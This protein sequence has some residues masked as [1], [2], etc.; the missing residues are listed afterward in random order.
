M[1]AGSITARAA[2][3][4]VRVGVTSIALWWVCSRVD[5]AKLGDVLVVTPGVVFLAPLVG[6]A[7]NTTLLAYRMKILFR[8]MGAH[9]SLGNLIRILC[10]SAFAGLVLPQGGAEVVKGALLART[11]VGLGPAV[12]GLVAVKLTHMP[13]LAVLLGLAL[14]TGTLAAEP[15]LA[16]VAVAYLTAALLIGAVLVLDVAVPRGTPSSIATRLNPLMAAIRSLRDHKKALWWCMAL[17]APSMLINAL[18]VWTLIAHFG[19]A[20]PL[21]DVLLLVPAMDALILLPI[22]VSG[23]GVRES[24]F[25]IAFASRGLPMDS[26]IAIGLIRWTGE[27]TRAAIGCML[28]LLTATGRSGATDSATRGGTEHD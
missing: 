20:W 1:K 26:A 4:W 16:G 19:E 23:I 12:A 5:I 25:A 3:R 8:A 27:L 21:L 22:S 17:S 9:L 28:W 15:M 14:A 11:S 2:M 18:V 7:V 10:R 13:T 6:M 24:V